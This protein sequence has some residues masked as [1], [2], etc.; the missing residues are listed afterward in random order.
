MLSNQLLQLHICHC[1]AN[2]SNIHV[3]VQHV[4]YI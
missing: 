1:Y 4:L 2:D 3:E